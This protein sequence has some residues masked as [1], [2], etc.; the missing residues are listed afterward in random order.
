MSEDVVEYV[1]RDPGN[2]PELLASLDD[3][4]LTK[5]AQDAMTRLVTAIRATGEK[6]KLTI[7][8]SLT[9]AQKGDPSLLALTWKVKVSE[10]HLKRRAKLMYSTADGWLS[11]R[12]ENQREFEG[13][14]DRSERAEVEV[15][16]TAR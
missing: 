10:P 2:V 9:P 14:V 13:L 5:S 6:G 8:L 3:R 12:N 4:A 16:R 15:L 1:T 11:N 7:E